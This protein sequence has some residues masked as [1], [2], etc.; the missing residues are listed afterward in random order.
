MRKL[1]E[2]FLVFFRIGAFT[3]GGGYAMVPLIQEEICKNK[4]WISDDEFIDIIAI[5]QSLPGVLAVNTATIVGYKIFGIRGV[6]VSVLGSALPSFVSILVIAIFFA[7][8]AKYKG[9]ELVFKGIRP[10]VVALIA[11]SVITLGKKV[12]YSH[13]NLIIGV[14]ASILLF[15]NIHPILIVIIS[16]I[17]GIAA[18]FKGGKKNVKDNN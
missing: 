2:L 13:F 10:A 18:E 14:T 9:T 4:K 15:L 3:L 17:I 6:I 11:Y 16:G 5:A 8:F 7:E 1:F 12:G